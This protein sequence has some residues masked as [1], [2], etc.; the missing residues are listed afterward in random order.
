MSLTFKKQKFVTNT[1]TTV[2]NMIRSGDIEPNTAGERLD[3]TYFVDVL[4]GDYHFLPI[5]PPDTKLEDSKHYIQLALLENH[6]LSKGK[7]VLD[8]VNPVLAPSVAEL[9]QGELS[10]VGT[11]EFLFKHFYSREVVHVVYVDA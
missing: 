10:R 4:M 9:F 11:E 3:P 7:S 8:L 5:V 6:F 2:L 1:F